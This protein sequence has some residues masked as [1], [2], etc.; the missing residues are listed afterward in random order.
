MNKLATMAA[1]GLMTAAT[2]CLAWVDEPV[3]QREHH[4]V[5]GMTCR[6]YDGDAFYVTTNA[7]VG[8]ITIIH[9][10]N[11]VLRSNQIEIIKDTDYGFIVVANGFDFKGKHRE[12]EMHV[13]KTGTRSFLYVNR[14]LHNGI[15]CGPA[16]SVS[17]D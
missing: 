9:G 7:E 12:I 17:N 4:Q 3:Q 14:D 15:P 8:G 1:I 10:R 13:T 5:W 2:P 16:S 11:G 6:P